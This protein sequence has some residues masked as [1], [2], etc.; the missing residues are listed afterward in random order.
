MREVMNQ[1][2]EFEWQAV[3]FDTTPYKAAK[4]FLAED[5]EL[6][7]TQIEVALLGCHQDSKEVNAVEVKTY[8]IEL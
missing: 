2:G 4:E 5:L 3:L 6:T 1:G 7:P 8:I